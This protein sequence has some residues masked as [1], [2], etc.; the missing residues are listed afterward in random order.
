[1]EL[2]S[3]KR[4]EARASAL[5]AGAGRYP[6]RQKLPSAL[7]NQTQPICSHSRIDHCDVDS[8]FRKISDRGEQSESTGANILW[9]NVVGDVHKGYVFG[10]VLKLA[11]DHAL[12]LRRVE[13]AKVAEQRYD[14]HLHYSR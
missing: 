11:E 10:F 9:R 13:G 8:A 14:L 12:H 3:C 1:M 4:L 7:H 5:L 2:R 6:V